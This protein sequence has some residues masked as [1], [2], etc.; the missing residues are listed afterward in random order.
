MEKEQAWATTQRLANK[1]GN[2]TIPTEDVI[3]L[4]QALLYVL[5]RIDGEP[6]DHAARNCWLAGNDGHLRC[7]P[8]PL[9]PMKIT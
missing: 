4:A 7:T 2:E 5:E 3:D 6:P 9:P 1:R 8:P